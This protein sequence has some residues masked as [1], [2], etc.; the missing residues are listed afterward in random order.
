MPSPAL[1]QDSKGGQGR[2]GKGPQEKGGGGGGR[3]A[4]GGCSWITLAVRP[5]CGA[6]AG[7]GGIGGI[8]SIGGS[9]WGLVLGSNYPCIR[10]CAPTDPT[11]ALALTLA[12]AASSASTSPPAPASSSSSAPIPAT[13]SFLLPSDCLGSPSPGPSPS[14]CPHSV[15]VGLAVRVAP[16]PALAEACSRYEWWDSPGAA[17]LAAMGGRRGVVVS[18]SGAELEK[19]R[20]GESHG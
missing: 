10:Q 19:Y 17:R 20:V 2:K 5:L 6:G 11:A 9:E 7:L 3:G 13:L 1:P 18:V 12:P 15:A 16:P 14:L 8:G 4:E